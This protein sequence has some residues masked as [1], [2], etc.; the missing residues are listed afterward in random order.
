MS[1]QS[2]AAFSR[3]CSHPL[4]SLFQYIPRLPN[5]CQ[6]I[7]ASIK[8]A[9]LL[10]FR[11]AYQPTR[12]GHQTKPCHPAIACQQANPPGSAVLSALSYSPSAPCL[13]VLPAHFSQPAVSL[14]TNPCL[15][16]PSYLPASQPPGPT[17][18][19]LPASKPTPQAQPSN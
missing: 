4:S 18:L 7:P 3:P 11:A 13:P 19:L 10:F 15:K 17:I 6:K 16:P 9:P 5:Y 1:R 14:P 8:S 2:A 12:P